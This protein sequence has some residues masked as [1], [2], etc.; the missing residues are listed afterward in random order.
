MMIL[1][2]NKWTWALFILVQNISLKYQKQKD[3]FDTQR[4]Y[5]VLFKI[6]L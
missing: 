4:H 6:T 5:S 2:I 3:V 1:R